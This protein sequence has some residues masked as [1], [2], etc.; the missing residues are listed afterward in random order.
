M[1]T[2][3]TDYKDALDHLPTGGTLVFDDVSW[4]DYEQL[5]NEIDDRPGLRVAYNEGKLEVMSPRPE[6]EEYKRI[7]ERIIDT[8]SDELDINVEPRGSATW[9]RKPDKGAE[10]DTCY[11]VANAERIIGRR[12]ID[13][14]KDP[15]PDLIVEVDSTNESL[16]K[17][18][19]YS[20]FH[21]PEIWRYDVKHSR[22]YMYELKGAD[23][24]AVP[25]S[26]SFP[27]LTPEVLAEFIGL[28]KTH[29][30]KAAL[31]AFREWLKKSR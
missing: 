14:T 16:S 23:Y 10:G 11:Y 26:R 6:H 29:G 27:I 3:V 12:D 17:F 2:R 19:I 20:S 13:I 9:K 21:V 31:A 7:I 25:S 28:S 5:L 1:S 4:D 18:G 22:V 24:A 8:L 15:P 30:Q